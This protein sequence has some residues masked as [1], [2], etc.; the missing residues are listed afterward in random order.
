MILAK[1]S[2]LLQLHKVLSD[3]FFCAD[4]LQLKILLATKSDM[5]SYY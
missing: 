5:L 2:S 1:T 3:S 4:F